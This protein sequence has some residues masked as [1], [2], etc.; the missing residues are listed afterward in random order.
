MNDPPPLTSA[1]ASLPV[2]TAVRSVSWVVRDAASTPCRCCWGEEVC[3]AP[4]SAAKAQLLNVAVGLAGCPCSAFPRDAAGGLGP[5]SLPLT[6]SKPSGW[7]DWLWRCISEPA[8]RYGG[9][10]PP[11]RAGCRNQSSDRSSLCCADT[12]QAGCAPGKPAPVYTAACLPP[13]VSGSLRPPDE[14]GDERRRGT[15]E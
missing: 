6:P 14:G 1:A 9:W 3:M 8:A 2:A 13:P 12:C 10:S 15:G 7:K 4:S 11:V 5:L